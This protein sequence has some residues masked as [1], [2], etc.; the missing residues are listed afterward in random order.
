MMKKY[1][2]TSLTSGVVPNQYTVNKLDKKFTENQ[3]KII[4]EHIAPYFPSKNLVESVE[5]ARLLKRPLLLRGEPGSGKTKLAQAVAYEL[6]G[7]NYRDHYFEWHIKS[8]S[9]AVDGLYTFDHLA[10]LRD[11]HHP[12]ETKR[13]TVF[14]YREFGPLGEAFIT[15]TKEKPAILLIDEVDKAD[16]DFPNDLLLELDQ[17]RFFI[18]ETKEQIVADHS[19]I[20]FITSNDERE[21]PNAFLRRCVFHYIDF[22]SDPLLLKIIK[23]RSEAFFEE[24]QEMGYENIL[25]LSDAVL[26]KIVGDFRK[27]Y[28]SMKTNPNTRK[29]PSTSELLDWLKVIHFKMIKGELTLN[30]VDFP[31]DKLLYPEVLLKSLDDQKINTQ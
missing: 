21:L 3:Q 23:G 4:K 2:G 31:T 9:K 24:F 10:R 13:K 29:L 26:R 27:L 30:G 5:Y 17:K 19:P 16:I 14:E 8:T 12:D 22:P 25:P 7:K 18:E 20:I 1:N 28:E 6:Y 11:A 15:S